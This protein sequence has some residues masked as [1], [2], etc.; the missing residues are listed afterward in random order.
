VSTIPQSDLAMFDIQAIATLHRQTVEAWHRQ[1]EPQNPYRDFLRLVCDQ[2]KQNY[3]LWHQE[4]IARS[5]DA[6]DAQIATV[7]RAIDKLNQARNDHIEQLDEYLLR[8]LDAWGSRP[9][10]GAKLNTETPGSA[11]DRLSIISLRIY[12]MAEQAARADATVEHR[13]KT[14][15]KLQT[16]H[17]QQAD[18]LQSL[19]QLLKD[20]FAG[21]K[22]LR[23]YRQFKMYNDPTLNPYLYGSKKRPAA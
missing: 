12:H 5:P 13:D 7:K 4:D 14:D 8:K 18:L 16:L 1:D 19:G 20:I 3:L 11:I 10:P 9:R 21:R 2:H 15:A 22:L 23:L 17:Q 6:T